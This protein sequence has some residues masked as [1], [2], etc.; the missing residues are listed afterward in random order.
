M[1]PVIVNTCNHLIVPLPYPH[2]T[3]HHTTPTPHTMSSTASA[4]A[5]PDWDDFGKFAVMAEPVDFSTDPDASS[6]A[7]ITSD[8][9]D[10][11]D[12]ETPEETPAEMKKRKLKEKRQRQK[13]NKKD[14]QKPL[15]NTPEPVTPTTKSK[16]KGMFAL[17]KASAPKPIVATALVVKPIVP[18]PIVPEPSTP[19]PPKE[20]SAV[21]AAP[22]RSSTSTSL[23]RDNWQSTAAPQRSFMTTKTTSLSRDNWQ[24]TAAPVALPQKWV[25]NCGWQNPADALVCSMRSCGALRSKQGDAD[26][27]P[28]QQSQRQPLRQQQVRKTVDEDGWSTV[29]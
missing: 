23:S 14:K 8:S 11:D 16:I 13:K 15:T 12:S 24:S 18:K 20:W 28:Q 4:F 3:P 26:W 21:A 5:E 27:R 6:V 25:C 19:P 2:T 1:I 22:Q 7:S 10:S 29:R 17:P 9:W